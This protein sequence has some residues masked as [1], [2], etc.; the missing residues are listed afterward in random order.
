MYQYLLGLKF[1]N[2]SDFCFPLS[3]I[4]TCNVKLGI[5]YS[6]TVTDTSIKGA[7]SQRGHFH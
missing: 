6:S 5:A 3:H 2:Q 1:L 7:A 4:A